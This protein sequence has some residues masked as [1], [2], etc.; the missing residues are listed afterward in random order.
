[1]IVHAEVSS[2]GN[3]RNSLTAMIEGTRESFKKIG[4][5]EDVFKSATLLADA[6]YHSEKNMEHI[7]KEGIDAYIADN[8]FRKRDQQFE[9]QARHRRSVDRKHIPLVNNK[10]YFTTE[11]F[12]LDE[13]TGKLIC[14]AGNHLYLSNGN[15]YFAQ[16][17]I[18]GKLYRGCKISCRK[19][20]F[21]TSCIR[22]EETEHGTV[23]ISE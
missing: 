14:P 11:D 2:E 6:G 4:E 10:K 1:M 7:Y 18:S 5:E 8:Q 20:Q 17:G 3:D 12:K 9:T 21:K 13:K 23:L 15:Y 19:S 22:E 16:R